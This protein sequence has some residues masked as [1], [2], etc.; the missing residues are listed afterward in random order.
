M[1]DNVAEYGKESAGNGE[2]KTYS[3]VAVEWKVCQRG[4]QIVL[5]DWKKGRLFGMH[6]RFEAWQ[7][8]NTI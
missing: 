3:Q 4:C 8:G 7:C 1:G 2:E 6:F 5:V